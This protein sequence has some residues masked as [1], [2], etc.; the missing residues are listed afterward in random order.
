MTEDAEGP[1][2]DAIARGERATELRR[3]NAALLAYA[4]AAAAAPDRAAP[5][6]A[7]GA[8]H[9]AAGR[10]EQAIEAY[11]AALRRAPRDVT[12]LRGRADAYERAG[13]PADAAS[14]LDD[15]VAVSEGS[16]RTLEA[17][18]LAR[19]ALQLAESRQRRRVLADLVGRVRR[20]SPADSGSEA[21]VVIAELEAAE[22]ILG[23]TEAD[24]A[25]VLPAGVVAA[26]EA[27]DA[28]DRAIDEGRPVD[29]RG[30]LLEAAH[31]F[32]AA[33]VRD[34]ALDACFDA[35]SVAPDDLELHLMLAETY[36][37]AGW[38]EHL[39]AKAAIVGRYLDLE[40]DDAARTRLAAIL[41][42]AKAI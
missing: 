12:A 26:I 22:A 13:R 24:G 21:A 36:A 34:A 2:R 9:L 15:L 11:D 1:Y 6:L 42:D 18:G 23:V 17:L 27:L 30:L 16:D 5:Y 31:S 40:P 29:A 37:A 4:E 19:Q 33:G 7:M 28:A 10:A 3:P 35:L 14:T 32:A 38:S 8:L 25:D 41:E 20:R 39:E